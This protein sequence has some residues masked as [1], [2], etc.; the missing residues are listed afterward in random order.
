MHTQ[1]VIKLAREWRNSR[2]K[3]T[4]S[5]VVLV[6]PETGT[7]Y[8][9]KNE[10]RDPE[11]ERPGMLAVDEYDRIFIATGGND[12]DGAQHWKIISN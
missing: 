6:N 11:H 5:G 1:Q 12:R 3:Y 7:V 4:H 2:D 8:G 10:L 9:W